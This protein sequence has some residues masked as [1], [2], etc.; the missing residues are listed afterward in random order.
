[1]GWY[2]RAYFDDGTPLGS[3]A[4]DECRIDSIAQSWSGISGAG[5]HKRQ[6]RAMQ[7]FEEL[8]VREDAT[9]LLLLAPPFDKTP[10]D[11]G[12]IPAGRAGE[13]RP[14]HPC[15]A[16]GRARYGTEGGG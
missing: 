7:S 6:D 2:R 12:Y 8:L 10:H 11:P 16:L 15:G 5:D 3:S 13:R 14:V 4:S 9:L 1:M